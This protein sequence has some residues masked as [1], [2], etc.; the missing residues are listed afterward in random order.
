MTAG[1]PSRQAVRGRSSKLNIRRESGSAV[2]GVVYEISS[3]EVPALD[4]ALTGMNLTTVVTNDW[5]EDAT[6]FY[7]GVG[8]EE[9]NRLRW[10]K[11]P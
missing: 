9:V 10:W 4:Q 3:D 2:L 1:R 6:G 7:S 8:F 11:K 5:R